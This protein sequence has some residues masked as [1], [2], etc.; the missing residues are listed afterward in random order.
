VSNRK[1]EVDLARLSNA[2]DCVRVRVHEVAALTGMS[3]PSVWRHT[4]LGNLPAATKIGG[5][6]SWELGSLRRCLSDK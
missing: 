3:V 1:C 2:P 5:M 4:K 6:T